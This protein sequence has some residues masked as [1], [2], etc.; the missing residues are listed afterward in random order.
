MKKTKNF[1]FFFGR[2]GVKQSPAARR[3]HP[4]GQRADGR[5]GPIN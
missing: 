1:S 2:A 4:A 5:A 3:S